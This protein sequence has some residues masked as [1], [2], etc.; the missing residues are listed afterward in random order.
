S[1]NYL[2]QWDLKTFQL[3]FSYSLGFKITQSSF[4][5]DITIR[6]KG[7]LILVTS[8]NNIVI[9]LNGIHFP[10]RQIQINGSNI[11]AEFLSDNYLLVFNLPEE[12]EK[13]DI[14]L[15]H[16]TEINRQPIDASKIFNDK[17]NEF[18]LYE[19][20][21]KS[22]KAFG[23][24]DGTISSMNLSNLKWK[25][26]F[27][28]N[29]SDKQYEEEIDGWN[30]YLYQTPHH[31]DTF[32]FPDVE[33]IRSLINNG[34]HLYN[35]YDYHEENEEKLADIYFND[36]KYKW[37]IDWKNK[38]L[39]VCMEKND[40]LC[41]KK[42]SETI[43]CCNILNSNALLVSYNDKSYH[44]VYEYDI[45]NNKITVPENT[46][47]VYIDFNDQ[48]YKWRIHWERNSNLKL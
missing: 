32:A 5:E 17:E 10:F 29:Y 14:S 25:E 15:Y 11:K 36:Q 39:S 43:C 47:I 33:N 13:Q 26:F 16:I 20:N 3:E 27:E 4:P 40:V 28:S 30:T 1:S 37:Q 8:S 45:D 23:L 34:I 46:D 6:S 21:S 22:K 48:Q 41:S 2:F 38:K 18:N 19:Y 44:E 35:Y 9:F 12:G 42:L 7:N 31:N 24:V